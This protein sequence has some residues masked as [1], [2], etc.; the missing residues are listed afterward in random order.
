MNLKN[1]TYMKNAE[2][3]ARQL[4]LGFTDATGIVL[5]LLEETKAE[6]WAWFKAWAKKPA[7]PKA[8]NTTLPLPFGLFEVFSNI[9]TTRR[10][11]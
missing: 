11:A 1:K 5:Q 6:A 7:A 2:F 4:W 10:A 8:I 9:T 3:K